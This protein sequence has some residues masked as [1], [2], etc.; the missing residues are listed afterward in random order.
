MARFVGRRVAFVALVLVLIVFFVHMGMRMMRNSDASR[1]DY[2]LVRYGQL[3]WQD[4]RTTLSRLLRGDMGQVRSPRGMVPVTEIVGEAYRNSMGL[5]LVALVGAATGGLCFGL[6]AALARNRT[7]SFS[8]L[9]VT[10]IGISMPAF[11]LGLLLQLG[12]LKYL[13]TFGRRLVSIAGFGWDIQHML[14]PVLVLA[15][16]PLAYL[17]RTTFLSL[18]QVMQEDYMRTAF[19]KGVSSSRAVRLHAMRN[20]A[21]PVIT[22]IGVAVRFSLGMLPVVEFFFAWP[23]MGRRLLEAIDAR[24]VSVVV[25]L[26]S[27]L[28]LTFLV[29]NLLLDITY[30]IVD[31]RTRPQPGVSEHL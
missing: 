31:P 12:E 28:G 1:P 15:A 2:D 11:F 20:V 25:A 30:R 16:R 9:M 24:Q 19:S 23:G 3:A 10:L 13:A 18:G 7:V 21:V 5:L 6:V 29:A 8:L 27:V 4:T 14:L 26:A 22:A 17:T